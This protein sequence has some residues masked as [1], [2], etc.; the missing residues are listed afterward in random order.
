MEAMWRM[1]AFRALGKP[2]VNLALPMPLAAS[3]EP[4][5]CALKP[6]PPTRTGLAPRTVANFELPLTPFTR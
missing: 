1:L 4:P 6:L 3:A 2:Q 5:F